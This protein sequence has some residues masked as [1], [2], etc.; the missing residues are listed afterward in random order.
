MNHYSII[1]DFITD[2]DSTTLMDRVNEVLSKE[3]SKA[4]NGRSFIID[5][6]DEVLRVTATKYAK[7][8]L[9]T[10]PGSLY[11]TVSGYVLQHY[12]S[13]GFWSKHKDSEEYE[14]FS[15]F[16]Y[17]NDSYDGGE[18]VIHTPYDETVVYKPVK[19]SLVW[20]PSWYEHSVAK[21]SNGARYVLV[22]NFSSGYSKNQR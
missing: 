11:T 6:K 20:M 17:L 22:V 4:A 15:A 12:S 16:I 3:S 21:V 18:L 1:K 5:S 9:E 2:E 10:F 13:K 8:I 14:E 19:N 7:K